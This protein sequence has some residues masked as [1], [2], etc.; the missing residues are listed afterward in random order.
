M[1][2]WK[3]TDPNEATRATLRFPRKGKNAFFTIDTPDGRYTAYYKYDRHLGSVSHEKF[4]EIEVMD[5]NGIFAFTLL[6]YGQNVQSKE[7]LGPLITLLTRTCVIAKR[8][9][10]IRQLQSS[11]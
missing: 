11:D 9:Q 8:I 5:S 7:V 3:I 4:K 10:I 2:S 1:T 6:N